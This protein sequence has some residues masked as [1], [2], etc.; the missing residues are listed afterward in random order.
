MLV[1]YY[2]KKRVSKCSYY[3]VYFLSTLTCSWREK[4]RSR[5]LCV[6]LCISVGNAIGGPWGSPQ[7]ESAPGHLNVI[8]GSCVF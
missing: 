2:D 3:N 8:L 5:F 6:A 4:M 7:I 1:V